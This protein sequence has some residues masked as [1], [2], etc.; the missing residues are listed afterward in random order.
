MLQHH[1]IFEALEAIRNNLKELYVDPDHMES[2]S[3]KNHKRGIEFLMDNEFEVT[4]DLVGNYE[5]YC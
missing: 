1:K 5:D 3:Y 2:A 4:C